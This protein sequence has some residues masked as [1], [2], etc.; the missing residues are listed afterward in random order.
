MRGASLMRG[1]LSPLPL[2]STTRFLGRVQRASF[3]TAT[4]EEEA[5]GKENRQYCMCKL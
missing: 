3:A 2:R 5:T 4:S 1:I